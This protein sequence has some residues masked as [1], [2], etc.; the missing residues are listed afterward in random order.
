MSNELPQNLSIRHGRSSIQRQA[1]FDREL[2]DRFLRSDA[3]ADREFG[4]SRPDRLDMNHQFG[5]C[6]HDW[7]VLVLAFVILH[8]NS[9]GVS[10][11]VALRRAG[12]NP[13][14]E[15]PGSFAALRVDLFRKCGG[16]D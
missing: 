2:A 8:A 3:L 12:W 1:L 9:L 11:V 15:Q 13:P 16:S 4:K 14:C 6:V 5:A 10:A 7:V